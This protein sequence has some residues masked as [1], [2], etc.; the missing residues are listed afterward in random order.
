MN[1]EIHNNDPL[2][3]TIDNFLTVDECNHMIQISKPDMARSLVCGEKERVESAG[4]TSSNSWIKHDHDEITLRIGQKIANIVGIPLENAESYQVI[5]YDINCEYKNHYDSWEHDGSEK[6]LRCM[7]YGGARLITALVYLNDV[8]EGG[9]TRFNRLNINV[10]P[11]QGKILVF[12]NTY[13]GTNFIRTRWYASNKRG[14]IC[15]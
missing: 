7:K 12:E 1:K 15:F 6:T 14:K 13:P 10:L 2:V 4:R 3:L 9:S 11:K 5:Y 8:E